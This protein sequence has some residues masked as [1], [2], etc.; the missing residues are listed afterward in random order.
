[1][2]YPPERLILCFVCI[3]TAYR[4]VRLCSRTGV[5]VPF[6]ARGDISS[7]RQCHL[8]WAAV[9]CPT[10]L[11]A[12]WGNL[13]GRFRWTYLVPTADWEDLLV[14]SGLYTVPRYTAFLENFQCTCRDIGCHS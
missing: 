3:R 13:E 6:H 11:E 8:L 10:S 2:V 4:P 14:Q 12:N 1:M 5:D 9:R 7:K